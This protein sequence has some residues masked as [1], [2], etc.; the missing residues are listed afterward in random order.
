[1][2]KPAMSTPKVLIADDDEMSLSMLE[3]ILMDEGISQIDKACNGR[4]ALE[5]FEDAL[6]ICP[7]SAVFLDISMPVMD[8]LEALKK[9]RAAEDEVDYRTAIIMAT[10][11]SSSETVA[12]SM[13]ELDAD[14]YVAK[15]YNRDEIHESLVRLGVICA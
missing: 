12:K 2:R 10:G 9:I 1:M 11:D 3:M 7:Y 6:C 4:D 15:P 13:V 8:G 5:M 14:E